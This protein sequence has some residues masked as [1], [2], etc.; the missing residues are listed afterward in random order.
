MNGMQ[1][2]ECTPEVSWEVRYI[3]GK[4]DE[5]IV[6]QRRDQGA[7]IDFAKLHRKAGRE[8]KLYR[9]EKTEVDF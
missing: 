2:D 9:V 4:A 1:P 6:V 7:A 3:S 8:T 5:P